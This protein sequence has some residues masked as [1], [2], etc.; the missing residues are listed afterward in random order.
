MTGRKTSGFTLFEVLIALVILAAAAIGLISLQLHGMRSNRQS[1]YQSSALILATEL[2]E[3]M[4][5]N[6][7]RSGQPNP[8]LFEFEAS[9]SPVPAKVQCYTAPCLPQ[10][11]AAF[12]ISEWQARLQDAL[13]AARAVVCLDS[14][15]PETPQW[16][17]PAADGGRTMAIKIGWRA[18]T[19]DSTP[20]PRLILPVVLPV[21]LHMIPAGA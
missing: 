1:A 13:P 16:T 6:P 7:P 17:C 12:S 11:F 4:R 21:V 9:T 10:E 19:T 5:A 8:Y 3:I 18:A 2:A 20:P 15:P 14:T